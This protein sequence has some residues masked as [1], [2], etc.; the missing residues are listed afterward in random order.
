RGLHLVGALTDK[1][2]PVILHDDHGPVHFHLIPYVDPSQVGHTFQ[3][4]SIKTHDD[5]YKL[6]TN[7]IKEKMN[8]GERH[9]FIG[10]AFVTPYGEEKE[11][12]SESERPLSI[13][14]AEYVRADLFSDFHYTALGHLH[15]AHSVRGE[16]IRYSGSPLKYSISEEK[17]KKGFLI[18]EL[19]ETGEATIEKKELLAR[20]DL[21]TV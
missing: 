4:D 3:D 13:G 20:R 2:E 21:Y 9:V 15:R 5:A 12:T 7:K 11:N 1:L 16:T 19:D 17:H 6:I 8:E 10:H 14:G 18:V